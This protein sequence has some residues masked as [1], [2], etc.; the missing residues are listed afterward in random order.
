MFCQCG[1]N[2]AYKLLK[3]LEMSTLILY[4]FF[5]I[6]QLFGYSPC[7]MDQLTPE[8]QKIICEIVDGDDGGA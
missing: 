7:E 3:H 6:A 1:A 2:L 8:Q 4:V 5:L